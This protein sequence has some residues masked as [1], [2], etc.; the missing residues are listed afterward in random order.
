VLFHLIGTEQLRSQR[1]VAAGPM[2]RPGFPQGRKQTKRPPRDGVVANLQFSVA[3]RNP[4]DTLDQETEARSIL[5]SLVRR[6]GRIYWQENLGSKA[7][8]RGGDTR[9]VATASCLMAG[10]PVAGTG[11]K[12]GVTKW[13]I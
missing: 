13:L 4:D 3:I 10:V 1:Q 9:P 2:W 5:C 6:S 12:D 7:S 11:A 8:M